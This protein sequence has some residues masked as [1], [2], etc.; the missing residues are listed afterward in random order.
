MKKLKNIVLIFI[1]NMVFAQQPYVP[2]TN[3][4]DEIL[5][6]TYAYSFIHITDIHIGEGEGDYGSTGYLDDT[7]PN[8]DVGYSAIRLRKAVNWINENHIEK[9]IKFVIVSGDITDSGERSELE[10]AKEILDDLNI[11]YIPLIG[12]HDVWPYVEYQNEAPKAYGDSI[13]NEVFKT[14]F[15][16]LRQF[17]DEYSDGTRLLK[18]YNPETRDNAYFQNFWY[19]Y[20][21][22]YFLFLDFNPRYH[23]RKDEP[24]IGPEAQLMDF[25]GG[26]FR[27][28]INSISVLPKNRNKDI[29]ITSHHPPAN[30]IYSFYNGFDRTE[31]DILTKGL[32]QYRNRTALWMGGHVHRFKDYILSTGN[33]YN[34][35][36]VV[37]TAANKEW[38]NGQMR[39][40][41]VYHPPIA[42]GLIE[43]KNIKLNIS[44]NPSNGILDISG[45]MK[46]LFKLKIINSIGESQYL[47]DYFFSNNNN[48]TIDV[49]IFPQGNYILILENSDYIIQK[50]F[51]L[52]K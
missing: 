37:E 16:E 33:G 27:W 48:L 26:T 6:A 35:C 22:D 14:T 41:N 32:F 52:I 9:N 2:Q 13:L 3:I 10:K 8:G 1:A 43:N 12:N 18:T 19:K 20:Q 46:G 4:N 23:V 36:K 31:L 50:K 49:S 44:P 5:G 17:F 29:F 38:K 11:P 47:G 45:S 24:G 39:L 7:M 28:L 34:I 30:E 42:T 21:G 40:I 15:E 51:L 25:E